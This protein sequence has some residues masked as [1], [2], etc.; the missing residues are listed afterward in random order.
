VG[1]SPYCVSEKKSFAPGILWWSGRECDER[2]IGAGSVAEETTMDEPEARKAAIGALDE[3]ERMQGKG[4]SPAH[5]RLLDRLRDKDNGELLGEA[6][7][8]FRKY[9]KNDDDNQLLIKHLF[10]AWH[11]SLEA[12]DM[13]NAFHAD[14]YVRLKLC[15][16]ELS[17]FFAGPVQWSG[18]ET[19][20]RVEQLLQ[21]LSWAID[22][23]ARCEKEILTLPQRLG[24]TRELEASTGPRVTF[25][26]KMTVAMRAICGRPLDVAVA[27]LA[28]IVM[29]TEVTVDQVI[30]ARNRHVPNA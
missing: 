1:L 13:L 4:L 18:E 16:E 9:C 23:F 28:T 24:L 30:S 5:R 22:I 3:F 20:A 29:E 14:D 10:S 17:A 25:T 15:A 7:Q 2:V 6:W 27:A 19:A 26:T 11:F 12:K 21:S 8:Q